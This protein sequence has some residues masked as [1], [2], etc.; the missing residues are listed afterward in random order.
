[1]LDD[2]R[3]QWVVAPFRADRHAA[4][5][6]VGDEWHAISA[7]RN[8]RGC[9]T[10]AIGIVRRLVADLPTSILSDLTSPQQ[11]TLFFIC[12]ELAKREFASAEVR[13]LLTFSA[14]G[15]AP[16]R[17]LRIAHGLAD[18]LLGHAEH[19]SPSRLCISFEDSDFADSLDQEF[20]AV[21]LRR[22]DPARLK[23]R[24]CT[25]SDQLAEPLRSA[26]K[27]FA[28]AEYMEPFM[29]ATMAVIPKSW[30]I[31]LRDCASGWAGEW[32]ILSDL[33]KYRDLS[34]SRPAF[35]NLQEFL[36]DVIDDLSPTTRCTLAS[37]Y[38]SSDC[39]SDNL[40]TQCSYSAIPEEERSLLHLARAQELEALNQQ[41][42][43]L[44]AIPLHYERQ[45]SDAA[46]LL[47]ASKHCMHVAFY[48]A[49]L[50]WAV[51]GRRMLSATD[52]GQTYCEFTRNILFALLLLN[53]LDEVDAICAENLARGDDPALLAHT[54]Y[55][56][57]ILAARLYEPSRRDYAAARGW[58]MKSLAFTERVPP[59]ETRAVNIAF[60][61]NTMALVEM[62][63]GHL[64]TAH[65]LLCEALQHMASEAPY[66]HETES[67]ILIHNRARLHVKRQQVPEA[68]ADLTA[69]VQHQ[70]GNADAYFD[71]GVLHQR[72]GQ[73]HE[74][75]RDFDAAIKWSPSHPEA[76]FN[77]AQTLVSLGRIN[78]SL[79][80]YERV[81]TLVPDHL[82]ALIDRARLFQ[83]RKELDA[84]RTDVNA[85]LLL[86]PANA[87]LLCLHGLLDLQDGSLAQAYESF[88]KAIEADASLPDAWANRATVF[89]QQG[90]L[91]RAC[92]DLTQALALRADSA[93]FYNRGRCFEQQKRWIEAIEDYLHALELASGDVRDIQHHLSVC[94]R[95]GGH[96]N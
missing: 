89:F 86:S 37:E 56:K 31:W 52:R 95:A 19:A 29:P 73:R 35:A 53:R 33:S 92:L 18:F 59:S 45:G 54:A 82:E 61:R 69:L 84:A 3:H 83:S 51:R 44:G 76:H 57:A 75:L 30:R 11:L 7:H 65:Q 28:S 38:V 14:E 88:T 72:S 93:A 85:A 23:I 21:L 6:C 68:I 64:A 4:G 90:E 10:G 16:S 46:P 78:E 2:T 22:A 17:T 74:A 9:Y 36:D 47:A 40:L 8:F 27:T 96:R 13:K 55:A 58:I 70:P 49:A 25:A 42:L 24:V 81:L 87:R 32:A 12:P 79:V 1:V 63:T 67:A 62:R 60:L 71:R 15:N 26:L 39:T 66:K 5:R 34:A 94:R 20:L 43:S 41:S 48:D 91:D 77:R 80:D 50:D